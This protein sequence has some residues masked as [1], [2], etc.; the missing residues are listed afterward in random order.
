MVHLIVAA[1][2]RNRHDRAATGATLP[3]S[4]RSISCFGDW[5]AHRSPAGSE[6]SG[7]SSLIALCVSPP[8]VRDGSHP[9]DPLLEEAQA[10]CIQSEARDDEGCT[11][12]KL[13]TEG[14]GECDHA[15][16]NL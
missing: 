11:R 7:E 13:V 12:P 14:D 4:L 3:T 2:R 6:R 15:D 8:G 5:N 1:P 10:E 16:W 9:P